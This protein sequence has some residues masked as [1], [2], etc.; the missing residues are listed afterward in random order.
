MIEIR[1]HGRGGQGAVTSSKIAGMA[2]SIEGIYGQALPFYGF[3]RRGAPVEVYLRF[4]ENPILIASQVYEPDGIIVLDPILAELGHVVAKG[5]K[6]KGFAV[7]NTLKQPSDFEYGKK[8]S[9]VGVVD[10]TGIAL[11]TIKQPISNT[12]I[13]GAFAR[14][15]GIVKLSSLE[16]AIKHVLPERL[17]KANIDS[18]RLAYEETK[19]EEN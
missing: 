11:K 16:E 3:E 2:A 17:Q 15:S 6:P 7:L 12:A 8:L 10:A 4:D 1:I 19:I 9:K 13:L 5:L 18:L 14:T